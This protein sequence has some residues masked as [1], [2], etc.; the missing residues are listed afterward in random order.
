VIIL[1]EKDRFASSQDVHVEKLNQLHCSDA[2]QRGLDA[3][4]ST[5]QRNSISALSPALDF[6]VIK[7]TQMLWIPL[8]CGR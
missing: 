5:D 1:V 6:D 2:V 4:A 3:D 7:A 8:E